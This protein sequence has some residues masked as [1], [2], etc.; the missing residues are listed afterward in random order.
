MA[1]AS[2]SSGHPHYPG[3]FWRQPCGPHRELRDGIR[4]TRS[5]ALDR[6][7]ERSATDSRRGDVRRVRRSRRSL[8]RQAEA[9]LV[10]VSP[11]FLELS[12]D[13][14]RTAS[15]DTLDALAAGHPARCSLN[16]RSLESVTALRAARLLEQTTTAPPNAIARDPP[17]PSRRTSA[18]QACRMRKS[19]GS[20]T[21]Q[22]R[23]FAQTRSPR[24]HRGCRPSSHGQ[25]RL[26]A[27]A[28]RACAGIRSERWGVPASSSRA[29]ANW[30]PQCG[31]KRDRIASLFSAAPAERLER[32]LARVSL[33]LGSQRPDVEEFNVPSRLMT[34]M[35]RGIPILA[36]VRPDSEV[37]HG[38]LV[39]SRSGGGWVTAADRPEEAARLAPLLLRDGW[40]R[41]GAYG[42]GGCCVFRTA[43]SPS[44]RP[45]RLR[46]NS[47]VW[48]AR[49]LSGESG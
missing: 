14:Q 39:T 32:E 38:G 45:T 26:L 3:Q 22:R 6:T 17:T 46:L 41:A 18:T 19:R 30:K 47:S 29:A 42:R 11:S 37:V 23:G 13:R 33:A 49:T 1:T 8:W 7:R 31:Q 12:G 24:N 27:G 48:P 10:A 2:K 9:I 44:S 34:L 40:E 25:H 5:T 15:S 35:A 36:S 4:V 28:G 20:T 43:P 16:D 21:P